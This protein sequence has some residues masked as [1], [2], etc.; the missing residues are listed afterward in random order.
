MCKSQLGTEW[1]DY[2]EQIIFKS[3]FG[4]TCPFW[5]SVLF[6]FFC[7]QVVIIH[8]DYLGKQGDRTHAK[9]TWLRL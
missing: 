9:G 7:H 8:L 4:L 2:S 3:I 1:G 6:L 5:L